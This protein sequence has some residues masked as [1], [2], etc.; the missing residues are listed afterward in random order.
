[1]IKL[2]LNTLRTEGGGAK[3]S[4][5]VDVHVGF[6]QSYEQMGRAIIRCESGGPL[7]QNR[8]HQGGRHAREMCLNG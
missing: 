1:M 3:R 5:L 6:L 2:K 4:D 7:G 8:T